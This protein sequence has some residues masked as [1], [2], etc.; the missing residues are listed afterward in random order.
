MPTIESRLEYASKYAAL[1]WPVLPLHWITERGVCS[2][3]KTYC[4]SAGKH[5]L[6][7]KGL[8]DAATDTK[9]LN[10]WF[11]KWPKANIGIRTGA[12]SGIF[13]LDIDPRHGGD[14]A[15]EQLKGELGSIPDDVVQDTGSGGSHICFR[16]AGPECRSTTN[17]YPGIDLRGDGGF[18]VVEPSNHVAGGDYFWDGASPLDG[19]KLPELPRKLL[20]KL[21]D[22]KNAMK[23][24]PE[25]AKLLP[26]SEVKRIRAAL[27]FISD[28][29][30]R[31]QWRAIGMALHSTGA[32]DQAFGLW[33]VG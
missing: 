5:P 9:T 4:R 16:Y 18:I 27:G 32:C 31:D 26:V 29:D 8:L 21:R 10:A 17:F 3:G 1:G 24:P 15:L 13:V 11:K 28:F 6:L 30:S 2:C 23:H 20:A 33:V 12:A 25:N 14:D 19:A 7:Q 22:K